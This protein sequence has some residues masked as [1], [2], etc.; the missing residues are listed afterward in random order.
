MKKQ[1]SLFWISIF[2]FSLLCY[3]EFVKN[4]IS[5]ATDSGFDTSYDSG[6]SSDSSWD[7][8]SSGSGSGTIELGL[9]TSIFIEAFITIHYCAF[10]FSFL[11]DR[12]GKNNKKKK[13]IA[14]W[15]LFIIRLLALIVLDILSPYFAILDFIL[16]FIFAFFLVF[17][18]M[19]E[20]KN[21]P[22]SQMNPM[23][24]EDI[25]KQIP[26]LNIEEFY[27][28][29][30]QIFYDVQMAWMEFDYDQ[31]RT[32]VTDNLYNT[33]YSQL[34]TL[35]MKNQKNVMTDFDLKEVYIQDI[36][37]NN[38][39]E[40]YTVVLQVSFY[41]Y[42]TDSREQVVRGDKYNKVLMTYRLTFVKEIIPLESCP[43]C[44]A[45]LSNNEMVCP[46]CNSH[47]QGLVGTM[48]LSKKEAISQ[49]K[50]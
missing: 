2:V 39:L 34:Q 32:L 13:K 21:K 3:L 42:I 28:Q 30:Y 5:L 25:H 44:S 41:D 29:A 31:L 36:S 20:S 26:N 4:P 19:S 22:L 45:P 27:S 10:V 43:N 33:Y 14:F 18:S 1:I 17:L 37:L 9:G 50:E 38:Q 48:R 23:S 46:Y 40:T 7:S 16:L 49:T 47:I 11:S 12:I 15:T 8:S 24:E 6:G 35:S